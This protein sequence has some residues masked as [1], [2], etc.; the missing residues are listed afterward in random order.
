MSYDDEHAELELDQK[1]LSVEKLRAE[2]VQAQL[3][4]WKRPAYLGGLAPILLALVGVATAWANGYFDTQRTQL[5][6]E[7]AALEDERDALNTK[8]AQAQQAIDYGYLQAKLAAFDADYAIGHFEAFSQQADAMKG[9]LSLQLIDLP[10][11]PDSL[12]LPAL[13]RGA[14]AAALK[15][16]KEQRDALQEKN[17]FFQDLQGLLEQ[18]QMVG[19]VTKDAMTNVLAQ[20]EQIE[21]TPWVKALETDPMLS[22]AQRFRDPDG[23]IFDLARWD[24]VDE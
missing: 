21:A 17:A 6:N 22:A 12:G 8:I 23:R 18:Q 5:A 24:W 9:P 13:M 4:W 1:R 16:L 14:E 3:A 11:V 20:L 19:E 15:V 10:E 2:V 7:I